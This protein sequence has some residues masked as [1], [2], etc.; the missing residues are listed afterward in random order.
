MLRGKYNYSNQNL[1][2]NLY[3]NKSRTLN[4]PDHILGIKE[5]QQFSQSRK[6][7]GSYSEH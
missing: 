7:V 6:H 1:E 5:T 4:K 3:S 2:V